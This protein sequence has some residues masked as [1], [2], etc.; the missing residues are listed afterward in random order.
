MSTEDE[1]I[2]LE[3]EMFE[4]IKNWLEAKGW[5]EIGFFPPRVTLTSGP[6]YPL[7]VNLAVKFTAKP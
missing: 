7:Q 2:H 1:L 4:A 6:P 3:H 5:T